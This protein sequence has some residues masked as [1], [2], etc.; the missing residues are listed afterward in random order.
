MKSPRIIAD[1]VKEEVKKGYPAPA[2]KNAAV[3]E[4]KDKEVSVEFLATKKVINTQ[5]KVI[6]GLNTPFIGDKDLEEDLKATI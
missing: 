6:G 1:F 3:H 2:V 4:F 5:H